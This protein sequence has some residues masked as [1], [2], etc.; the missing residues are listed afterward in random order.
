MERMQ[1]AWQPA[2]PNG[3]K[4]HC[5][6]PWEALGFKAGNHPGRPLARNQ[7][8]HFSVSSNTP[9]EAGSRTGGPR[10]LKRRS[11][12]PARGLV[13]QDFAAQPRKEAIGREQRQS[14]RAGLFSFLCHAQL[15]FQL[16]PPYAE[17]GAM[18]GERT[19][20][21]AIL[22]AALGFG[23]IGS[24]HATFVAEGPLNGNPKIFLFL[25][26]STGS[27]DFSAN[28]GTHGTRVT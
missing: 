23:A 24:A 11:P 20:F 25:N 19:V 15:T 12:V 9:V 17:E 6:S 7:S 18:R 13:S 22:A 10:I 4:W 27:T 2:A 14:G 21:G 3:A 8:S 5:Q 16:V 1:V 26:K 28:A